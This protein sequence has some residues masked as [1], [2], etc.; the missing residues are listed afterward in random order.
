MNN[1]TKEVGPLSYDYVFNHVFRK[2][3]QTFEKYRDILP[4]INDVENAI[5]SQKGDDPF[6]MTL[7]VIEMLK[8]HSEKSELVYEVFENVRSD[9]WHAL[10][11]EE[12]QRHSGKYYINSITD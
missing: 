12:V 9:F 7:D 11:P 5:V 3:S 1:M 2:L 4:A 10:R 6:Q 8:V